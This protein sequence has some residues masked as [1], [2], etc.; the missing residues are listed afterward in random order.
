MHRS[1]YSFSH[2]IRVR[3]SEVDRQGVVFNGHYFTYFDVA[4]TEYWREIG[5]PYPQEFE[6]LGCDLFVAK[7]TADYHRSARYDDWL[8]IH[9]RTFRIGKSSIGLRLLVYRGDEYLTFGELIYVCANPTT[10]RSVALP[11]PL[12]EHVRRFEKTPPE[13]SR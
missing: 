3:W 4:V 10:Q 13:M 12:I 6:A 1:D 8:D 7:A 2:R 9:C 11:E 5:V